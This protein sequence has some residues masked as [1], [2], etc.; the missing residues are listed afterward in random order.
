MSVLSRET[1]YMGV[2][3]CSVIGCQEEVTVQGIS[4]EEVERRAEERALELDWIAPRVGQN[5]LI[6]IC[7]GHNANDERCRHAMGGGKL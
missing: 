2:V 5:T 7:P 4:R 1:G 6:H 3:R